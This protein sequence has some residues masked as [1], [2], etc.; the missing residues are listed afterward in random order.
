MEMVKKYEDIHFV[1]SSRKVWNYSFFTDEDIQ[2][3][4][5]GTHY[6]LYDLFGSHEVEV[7]GKTGYYFAVW[8]PNAT[9]VS[10]I[11]NFNDWNPTYHPLYVRLDSSGIWE[12][13]IPNLPKGEVY[14]YHIDG[15]QGAQI[16]TGDPYANFWE[17]R[18][19]T[20]SITW[21]LNYTW[22]D[23]EWM[24]TRKHHNR[25]DAPCSIYEVH[26]ASW[27]RPNKYD[28][29]SYNTYDQLRELLVPYV[30]EM[31]FTHVEFMPIMEHPFD[32]SWGYQG[33]GYF[34]PTSR[35]GDPQS[36]MELVNTF[37]EAGIGVILDWV[38]SHFPYDAHGLFMFDGANTYEY[39]D[40]RK[41]FHPDWNSYVFNY[42]RGEVKSFLIS[43]AR[44]WFDKFHIDGIR[45]DAVSSMLKL[46]YSR[47]H[48][49]WEP[50]EY[51][52]DGNLEAINF[53]KDLNETIYRDFHDV[54]T[55]AEEATD[56]PGVS[57]PTFQNGLGFGMKWMMGWMHDTLDYFKMDPIH[58]RH[59]QNKFS[60]SMMYYYDENFL[61]PLSHDE[62]VHGKSPMI[63]KMPGDEWQKFA[64]LR[65][66]YT[67]MFTHPGGKLLFMGSEFGDTNE[68]NYKSELQWNLLAFDSHRMLKDC[69]RDLNNL[70]RNEPAM[71]ENQFNIYGF[72]W[73][74]LNHPAECVVAYRRKGKDPANDLLII[75]N[76]TPIARYD[77]KVYTHG[78]KEWREI[79][80]S[81][82]K[83]YW[84]TGDVYNPHIIT[85]PLDKN[86]N[87]YEIN[88]HLPSLGAIVLK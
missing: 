62:V 5:H 83:H 63:F 14:K 80:N 38:P 26:L 10:V 43:S 67:Y 16:D 85:T 51:G 34:A 29:E 66:L 81:D 17:K 88:V 37:H 79:F 31:G 36:F 59:Y 33:T 19:N 21:N 58:R 22:K 18:P 48:G 87:M 41:G 28:E 73:V 32:G 30:K 45:V 65:T 23:E 4:Q 72:E 56:W 42:K 54:Q 69:V 64:N 39:A 47:T 76:L 35:F 20:A 71:Y 52:G 13:F 40:M 8:A 25:L 7:L 11:G 44:F 60:F 61:L 78:K 74:D 55:I 77:W 24:Q 75:L 70:L 15:F 57:R 84:G 46:N 49:Q 3:F 9:Y 27:M 2:N 50:N 12:G 82:A 6:R 53:I 1:D 68:W 86:D